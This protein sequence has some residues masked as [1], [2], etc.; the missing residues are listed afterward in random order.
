MTTIEHDIG[1]THRP[2]PP[3]SRLL[4]LTEGRAFWEAGATLTMW[5]WL[6]LAPSGDGHPVLVLPGLLASD[7]STRLLRRYLADRGYEPHGWNLGRNLGPRAGVEEGMTRLL[8][9]L[10]ERHGGRKVSI[11]GWSL[12]GVYARILA[13]RHPELVRNVITLGSPLRGDSHS[14]NAWRVYEFVSGQSSHDPA[15]KSL[16]TEIPQMPTTSIYSRTDGVVAWQCSLNDAAQQTENVEVLASHI[17]LGAHP[18]V[19]Y[20]LADRL[21]QPEGGWKP[22][23][24][25]LFGPLVYPDPNRS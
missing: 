6:K 7:A 22:F 23:D 5:P 20:A 17:G 16:A 9:E 24:R 21:S 10:S 3:P 4:L 12:G 2:T 13:S 25:K 19:L 8:H 14:T 15:R 1:A 11:V 18:A